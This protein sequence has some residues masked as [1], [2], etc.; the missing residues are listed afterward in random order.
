FRRMCVS[1]FVTALFGGC[2]N[3]DRNVAELLQPGERVALKLADNVKIVAGNSVQLAVGFQAADEAGQ[4][5]D[6]PCDHGKLIGNRRV[7][8]RVQFYDENDRHMEY[9][10][11]DL[12]NH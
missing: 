12:T 11:I 10:D 9:Q 8:A 6:L 1:V 7:L 3:D 2:G 5:R 4:I